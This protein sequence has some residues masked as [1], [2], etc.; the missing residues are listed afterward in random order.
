MENFFESTIWK[1]IH[2]KKH[3]YRIAYE[4]IK[5]LNPKI[6]LFFIGDD[7]GIIFDSNDIYSKLTEFEIKVM[8][9]INDGSIEYKLKGNKSSK[10]GWYKTEN[11]YFKKVGSSVGISSDGVGG[12]NSTEIVYAST[13]V[14]FDSS[15]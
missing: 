3:C 4:L 12:N 8:R 15:F 11:H 7:H 9:S 13:F 1:L 10:N 2:G 14:P 6:K 5:K